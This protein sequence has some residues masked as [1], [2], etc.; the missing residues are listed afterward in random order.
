MLVLQLLL[1]LF[2]SPLLLDQSLNLKLPISPRLMPIF[3]GVNPSTM[4]VLVSLVTIL[5]GAQKRTSMPKRNDGLSLTSRKIPTTRL[6]VWKR[7][8][9]TLFAFQENLTL[10]WENHVRRSLPERTQLRNHH[11]TL[12]IILPSLLISEKELP[13]KLRFHSLAV[14]NQIFDGRKWKMMICMQL[15][16]KTRAS[17]LITRPTLRCIST[18][19]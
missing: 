16:K 7:A 18:R 5:S 11:S 14:L 2:A 1:D 10:V 6:W 19:T 12:Q 17:R 9:N 4:V 13:R 3:T 15:S 8:K